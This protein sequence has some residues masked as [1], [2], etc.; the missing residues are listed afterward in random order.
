[1]KLHFLSGLIWVFSS[2]VIAQMDHSSHVGMGGSSRSANS[3]AS[4]GLECA[5]SATPFLNADGS[6]FLAWT[7]GGVVSVA[8][9]QDL[10][11]SFAP[12]V[13]VAEH[14]KS[15][16]AGADAR[17]QV[18][19]DNSGNIFIAYAF[20]KD[21]NWNAQVN[22]VRSVDGGKPLVSHS[23]SSGMPQVNAFHRLQL[24]L[25]VLF[26]YFGLISV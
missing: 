1:M 6:L 24:L 4:T 18:V 3:C 13:V 11:K 16:D 2:S 7:A 5:N 15:L 21:S 9:S 22:M 17:P 14:G 10:G 8:K 25:A 19:A 12:A 23:Q 26:F 20:F